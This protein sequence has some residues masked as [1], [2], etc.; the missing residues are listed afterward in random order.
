MNLFELPKYQWWNHMETIMQNVNLDQISFIQNN[1]IRFSF[2]N[3]YNGGFYG[4][5]LCRKVLKCWIENEP[6]EDEPFA[7]FVLDIYKKELDREE[8][9]SALSDSRYGY[10]YP[11]DISL[12]GRQYLVAI[13]G[14]EI[15]ID[16]IC[17]EVETGN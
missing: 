8:L 13:I 12:L 15:C 1:E 14:N 9:A 17:G 11:V 3:S 2:S 5:L 16:L 10:G 4:N 6:F 7:Y